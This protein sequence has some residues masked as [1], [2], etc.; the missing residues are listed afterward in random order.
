[1]K[2]QKLWQQMGDC[3]YLADVTATQKLLENIIYTLQ[4]DDK[5]NLFLKKMVQSFE[6]DFKI[7]GMET[8]FIKRVLKTYQHTKG[9]L[10]VLLNGIKGQGKTITA[11]LLSNQLKQPV[12]IIGANYMGINTFLCSIPQHLTIFVDEYEKVFKGKISEDDYDY[13][14]DE[15]RSGDNTLLSIMDGVYKTDFRRVFLLTTN[16]TWVNENMINRPG[17]IRY[18]KQFKDLNLDQINEIIDDCLKRKKYKDDILTFLKPLEI[19]TVDIVKSIVIEVNIHDEEP[20]ICCKDFNLQFKKGEYMALKIIGKQEVLYIE[21]IPQ[22]DL[23]NLFNPRIPWKGKNL[24]I[25]EEYYY[26]QS[27]PDYDNLVFTFKMNDRGPNIKIR[28]TKQQ[29]THQSF[30]L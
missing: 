16:R 26:T 6:F 7:Y 5:G 1:M 14:S 25:G 8:A 3:L 12:I 29:T 27:A 21:R 18:L 9:N 13:N 4:I 24:Y 23:T 30:I 17:R 11:E 22:K 15:G 19:I 2:Q 20:T 10:G 28:F